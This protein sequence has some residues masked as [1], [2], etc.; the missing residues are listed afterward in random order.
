MASI[1]HQD[2]LDMDKKAPVDSTDTASL[3]DAGS[4][5]TASGTYWSTHNHFLQN[6]AREVEI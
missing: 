1:I 5:T 4:L 6:S 2:S 3:I